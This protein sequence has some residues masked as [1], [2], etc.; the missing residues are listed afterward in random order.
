M[1][2]HTY[3]AIDLKSFYA[4]V[5]CRDRGLDPLDTNLVVAD[6]SRTDKTICL[7]VTPTFLFGIIKR[8]LSGVGFYHCT[9][10]YGLLHGIQHPDL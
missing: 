10:A 2:Q 8:S 4:S 3:I 9:S 1:K 6:E 7:A 5:E